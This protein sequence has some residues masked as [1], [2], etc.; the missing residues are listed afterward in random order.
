MIIV[1]LV[2]TWALSIFLM[3]LFARMILSWVP[4]LIRDWQPRGPMLVAAELVYSA[5][6]P[7]LRLLRKVLPPV[8]VGNLML[9]LAFIGLII[10]IYILR[11]ATT[12]IFF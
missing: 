5:T 4:V 3:I 1:G 10:V 11:A 2:I 7:P 6:D 12:A 8:R 9:D